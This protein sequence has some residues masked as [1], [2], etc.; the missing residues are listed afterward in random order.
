MVAPNIVSVV[1]LFSC[2]VLIAMIAYNV[3]KKNVFVRSN[4]RLI[5]AI[6]MILLFS[7]AIQRYYW[8]ATPMLPNDTVAINFGLLAVFILFFGRIFGIGVKMQEE[9][10]LTI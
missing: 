9:Q 7:V 5:S 3:Y 6:G 2:S 1:T 4:A 10:D 8:D